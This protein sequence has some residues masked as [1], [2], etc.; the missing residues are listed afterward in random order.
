MG[1]GLAGNDQDAGGMDAV[2]PSYVRRHEADPAAG[3][4]ALVKTLSIWRQLFPG[5]DREIILKNPLGFPG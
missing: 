5:E 2:Q 4:T 3:A 1:Q